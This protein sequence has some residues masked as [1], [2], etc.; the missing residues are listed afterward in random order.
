MDETEKQK[1]TELPLKRTVVWNL[2]LEGDQAKEGTFAG[3]T[4][5]EEL[6]KKSSSFTAM[7]PVDAETSI[8]ADLQALQDIIN[9]DMTDVPDEVK[10]AILEL[11]QDVISVATGGKSNMVIKKRM[12]Q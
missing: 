12:A 11:F 1:G 10:Q 5:L 8:R 4:T 6:T 9:S 3:V 2:M 7:N